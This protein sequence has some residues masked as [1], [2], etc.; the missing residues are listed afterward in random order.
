MLYLESR[1]TW[2]EVVSSKQ[3]KTRARQTVTATIDDNE[4]KATVNIYH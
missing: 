4:D 2:V 3:P 1:R